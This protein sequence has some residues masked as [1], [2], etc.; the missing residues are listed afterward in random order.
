MNGIIGVTLVIADTGPASVRD[1]MC[2]TPVIDQL[3]NVHTW[4]P[5]VELELLVDV[6]SVYL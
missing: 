6:I 3:F 4:L 2:P 5:P 1:N